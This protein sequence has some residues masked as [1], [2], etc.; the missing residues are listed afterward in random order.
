MKTPSARIPGKK[1]L[2]LTSRDEKI[3][4]AIY[5]YRYMTILDVAWLLFKPSSKTHVGEILSTLAGGTD[6][7]THSYLCRFGLP[8]VGNSERV[9]TLGSKGRSFLAERG[10]PVTW[11]FRPYKLKH[12]SYSHVQHNLILTRFLVA[13]HVWSRKQSEFNLLKVRFGHEFGR[14]PGKV[15]LEI[16][17]KMTNVPVIPD[18]WLL[19]E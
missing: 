14:T 15:T 4:R 12:F 2:I 8:A 18:A 1:P 13:A 3:L 16:K 6:L 17:G 19:F 9:F 10:L 7:S 11:Y 5:A